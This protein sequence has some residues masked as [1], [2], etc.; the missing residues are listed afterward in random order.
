MLPAEGEVELAGRS[1]R[2]P[3]PARVACLFQEAPAPFDLTAG[4][5]AALGGPHHAEALAR[6][7]VSAEARV[8]ALSGGQRQRV[9]LAR[10]LAARPELLLL[11]EPTNHLDLGGRALLARVL[12]EQ[13]AAGRGAVVATHDLEL[14][15]LA[16]AV[17]LLREGAVA[18]VGTAAEVLQPEL[19]DAVFGVSLRRVADPLGSA[20]FLRLR[21]EPLP[22]TG[23]VPTTRRGE[24]TP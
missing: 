9:H 22:T 13:R 11:D 4:E 20:P 10:C 3:D 15:A 18:A 16:D 24:T 14:A 12:A 19:L 21:A 2:R 8:H 6:V 17:V 7:G 5:V 1:L 23:R